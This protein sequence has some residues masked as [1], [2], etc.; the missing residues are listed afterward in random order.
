V[1]SAVRQKWRNQVI[2][3]DSA[4]ELSPHQITDSVDRFGTVVSGVDVDPEWARSLG[5]PN[6]PSDGPRNSAGS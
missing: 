4:I 2:E 5:H 6:D 1:R 3:T